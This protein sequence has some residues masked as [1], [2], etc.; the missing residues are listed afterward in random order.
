MILFLKRKTIFELGKQHNL[1]MVRDP[2]NFYFLE[3]SALE[4]NVLP[5]PSLFL[6]NVPLKLKHLDNMYTTT[7]N[8]PC[9]LNPV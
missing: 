8:S 2:Q 9:I 1:L 3:R 5:P 6:S 7:P 4:T